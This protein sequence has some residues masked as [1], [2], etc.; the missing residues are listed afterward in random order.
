MGLLLLAMCAIGAI[1]IAFAWAAMG[2]ESWRD[3]RQDPARFD[4]TDSPS[5]E[6]ANDPPPENAA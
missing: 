2:W 6:L 1:G 3:G 5:A 4:P